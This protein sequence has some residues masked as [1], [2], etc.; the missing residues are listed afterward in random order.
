MSTS[1]PQEGPQEGQTGLDAAEQKD[2]LGTENDTRAT[3]HM[4]KGLMGHA[5]DYDSSIESVSESSEFAL[6]TL[7]VRRSSTG[8]AADP[9]L[10]ANIVI[11]LGIEF[12]AHLPPR[13]LPDI[14]D[15]VYDVGPVDAVLVLYF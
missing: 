10:R 13:K 8:A 7:P 3:L 15:W 11:G 4:P 2:K 12:L 5:K 9:D 6:H 14:A 1:S